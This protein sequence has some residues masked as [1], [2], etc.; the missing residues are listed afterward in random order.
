[1]EKNPYEG[2]ALRN[3]TAMTTTTKVESEGFH[4]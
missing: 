3:T 1:M 2:I 4:D